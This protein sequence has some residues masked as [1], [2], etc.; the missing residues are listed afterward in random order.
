MKKRFFACLTA[1]LLCLGTVQA[2]AAERPQ[3]FFAPSSM[4]AADEIEVPVY[5]KNIPAG[6]DGI[7]GVKFTFSYNTDEFTVKTGPDGNPILGA[8]EAML[9]QN[10]DGISAQVQE[11]GMMTVEYIDFTGVDKVVF[12]DGPL[13]YYTLIP[14]HP[15]SLYNSDDIYPLLFQPGSVQIM[16]YDK[17]SSSI[18]AIPTEGIDVFIGG[19]NVF[20]TLVGPE[21]AKELTFTAGSD[22]L[23]TNGEMTKMDTTPYLTETG[24][25]V[26]A[27]YLA[28]AVGMEV[29]WD[30]ETETVSLYFPYKSTYVM[31]GS[32]SIYI[33]TINRTDLPKPDMVDD[34]TFI[35]LSVI[36]AV[37]GD[38]LTVE[39]A[40]ESA[41]LKFQ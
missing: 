34:R 36:Q 2:F 32:D 11:S 28:E 24:M 27:R 31:L 22:Q 17:E 20:P 23:W 30:G 39:R 9:I 10:T 16:Q 5:L 25:M 37:F 21:I 29:L 15:K 26:P 4:N 7:C 12:R 3:L 33:N 13:F 1:V 35:D 40:E 19:Y 8:S 14:T 6:K 18:S 38:A 41:V